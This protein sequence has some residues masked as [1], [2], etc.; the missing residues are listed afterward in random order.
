MESTESNNSTRNNTKEWLDTKGH[1]AKELYQGAKG[2]YEGVQDK[3]K[4]S[5]EQGRQALNQG[6]E[7]SEE[8]MATLCDQVRANPLRSLLFSAIGGYVFAKFFRK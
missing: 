4:E 8:F 5:W 1:E 7:K 6:K 2:I 3:A